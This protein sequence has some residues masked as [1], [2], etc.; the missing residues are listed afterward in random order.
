MCSIRSGTDTHAGRVFCDVRD[1]I[2]DR[3]FQGKSMDV[4][5]VCTGVLELLSCRK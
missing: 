3:I 5:D 1:Q 2:L 4:T